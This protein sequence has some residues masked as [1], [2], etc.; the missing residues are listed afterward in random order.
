MDN[1]DKDEVQPSFIFRNIKY[2]L[3]FVWNNDRIMFLYILVLGF[4]SVFLSII[5]VYLP[6][7]I[8]NGLQYKWPIGQLIV[9]IVIMT[10]L[11]AGLNF[12]RAIQE[13][14]YS[15][16]QMINR[17]HL[18]NLVNKK[19]MT[20]KFSKLESAKMQL[21]I[22]QIGDLLYTGESVGIN[23][24]VGSLQNIFKM[25]LGFS[26]FLSILSRIGLWMIL[27]IMFT[28]L[29]SF[30]LKIKVTVF[31][32]KNRDNLALANKKI[33]YINAKLT[34][35][36][37]AKDIRIFS[38]VDW[39]MKK[40]DI[41]IREQY[42]WM[43]IIESKKL[44][45]NILDILVRFSRDT[46]AYCYVISLVIKQQISVAEFVLYVGAIAQLS[47]YL[48]TMFD[49]LVILRK[50]SFDMNIIIDFLEDS[51][52]KNTCGYS[53]SLGTAPFSIR[54][55]HVYFKYASSSTYVIEDLNI[56]IKKGEKIA[57]VGSNGAGKTTLIKLLCGFYKTTKG[58]IYINDVCIDDFDDKE[59]FQLF[60]VV[61]QDYLILPFSV[62]KNIAMKDEECIDYEKVQD[63]LEAANL[64]KRLPDMHINLVK[65][66]NEDGINLSGGETQKLLIARA[67]YKDAP[68]LLLDEPTAALDAVAESQLYQQ[69]NRFCTNKTSI[70]ISHRLASTKFCNRIFFLKDGRVTEEG[71]HDEL[72]LNKGDY[73]KMFEAQS[74]YYKEE[75]N[76]LDE[77]YPKIV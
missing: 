18:I 13:S 20:C 44:K 45:T 9:I 60:S 56:T 23:G 76:Q 59:Q 77:E 30:F 3:D 6:V 22:E 70:F 71:T 58:K 14:N 74:K 63:C 35:N 32:E 52:S 62:A 65:A 40:L 25:L 48:S 37:F 1:K 61:F 64:S 33:D 46:I 47:S 5:S 66:A 19:I 73:A 49:N 53:K 36:E 57:L 75:V 27:F 51:E 7:I 50:S 34:R 2:T 67:L 17:Q 43:K 72:L 12:I 55:E 29:I 39:L 10:L 21:K 54:F 26:L 28:A 4:A 16:K 11:I 38:C 31:L 41:R 42:S 8:I 15:T 24:M 69:Y 68:I